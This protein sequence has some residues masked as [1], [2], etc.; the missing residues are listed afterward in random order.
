VTPTIEKGDLVLIVAGRYA[1]T[2]GE[3]ESRN[4]MGWL[5]VRDDLAVTGIRNVHET[6]VKVVRLPSVGDA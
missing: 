3:V 1:G 4:A 2:V 5:R 6:K